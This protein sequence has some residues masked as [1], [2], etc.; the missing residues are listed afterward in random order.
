M[1][2][3]PQINIIDSGGSTLGARGATLPV[4]NLTPCSPSS[5][6]MHVFC[7]KRLGLSSRLTTHRLCIAL[8]QTVTS[9]ACKRS[10]SALKL[11][12]TYLR[13]SRIFILAVGDHGTD[14][15]VQG[16]RGHFSDVYIQAHSEP[17]TS[18]LH[19]SVHRTIVTITRHSLLCNQ[20]HLYFIKI[21]TTLKV[22]N[23]VAYTGKLLDIDFRPSL[24]LK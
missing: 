8:V 21:T 9:A 16:V 15:V 20:D 17:R 10:F 5:K 24:Q 13:S 2:Q 3:D 22:R 18:E 1:R 7:V 6:Q 11:I 14:V 4:Q 23:Q 19:N 12:K